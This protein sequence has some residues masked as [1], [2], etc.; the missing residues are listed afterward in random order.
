[1]ESFG[2]SSP[3][4][5]HRVSRRQDCHLLSSSALE[6]REKLSYTG[7]EHRK[8]SKGLIG[9]SGVSQSFSCL[10]SSSRLF[11]PP[12]GVQRHHRAFERRRAGEKYRTSEETLMDDSYFLKLTTVGF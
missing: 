7:S 1:V 2:R 11:K 3:C 12:T 5:R 10:A 4:F 9:A 8:A 6:T